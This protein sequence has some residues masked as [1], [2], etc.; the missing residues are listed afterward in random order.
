MLY[1]Y[2][3]TWLSVFLVQNSA[4][5]LRC[6]PTSARSE[7]TSCVSV[8]EDTISPSLHPQ[9]LRWVTGQ[10]LRSRRCSVSSVS[11]AVFTVRLLLL[12]QAA[13]GHYFQ[14]KSP[15]LRTQ[16]KTPRR[17]NVKLLLWRQ[18]R[19]KWRLSLRSNKFA[20]MQNNRNTSVPARP[21][22]FT[23]S[24]KS[25]ATDHHSGLQ[26]VMETFKQKNVVRQNSR[27][28]ELNYWS[29][30]WQFIT[31][32]GRR[33]RVDFNPLCVCVCVC[34]CVRVRACVCVCVCVCVSVSLL[35]YKFDLCFL[36]SFLGFKVFFLIY[37]IL[38]FF[39]QFLVSTTSSGEHLS[40]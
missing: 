31:S 19:W 33:D 10:P 22:P 25:L 13:T 21:V 28:P 23:C 2:F 9:T 17:C 8:P 37:L 39:A 27:R 35:L 30:L 34:A 15:P 4:E 20:G 7:D 36:T 24:H 6:A 3:G 12:H 38:I 16:F 1:C 26:K 40:L 32:P 11:A 14:I 29:S 5:P 18:I